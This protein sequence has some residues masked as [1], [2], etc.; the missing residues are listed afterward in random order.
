MFESVRIG[1]ESPLPIYVVQCFWERD[2]LVR[3]KRIR[4]CLVHWRDKCLGEGTYW[5]Q[6][7]ERKWRK[8]RETKM[9]QQTLPIIDP[10]GYDPEKACLTVWTLQP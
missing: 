1:P 4:Y 7:E 5:T 3:Y 2:V 9:T 6:I 10:I 8:E